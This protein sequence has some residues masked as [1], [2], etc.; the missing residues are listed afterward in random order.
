M[1]VTRLHTNDSGQKKAAPARAPLPIRLRRTPEVLRPIRC[2]PIHGDRGGVPPVPRVLG[3]PQGDRRHRTA[4][5]ARA[6]A[7]AIVRQRLVELPPLDFGVQPP[8]HRL[9]RAV[10]AGAPRKLERLG[11][12]RGLSPTPFVSVPVPPDLAP[13]GASA[14]FF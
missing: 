13:S 8:P 9:G 14:V 4:T 7:V 10:T 2:L 5:P 12:H 6:A 11:P 3:D 1:R